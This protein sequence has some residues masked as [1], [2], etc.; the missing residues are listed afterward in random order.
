MSCEV[1]EQ[2]YDNDFVDGQKKIIKTDFYL[3]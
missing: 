2:L 3:F 1:T